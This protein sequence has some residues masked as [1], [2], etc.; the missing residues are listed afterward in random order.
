M[1]TRLIL[2]AKKGYI[3]TVSVDKKD[4]KLFKSMIKETGVT[5]DSYNDRER[6]DNIEFD[7][8]SSDWK[9]VSKIITEFKKQAKEEI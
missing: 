8:D 3:K 5:S 6:Y 9:K 7:F 2:E 4:A 1:I